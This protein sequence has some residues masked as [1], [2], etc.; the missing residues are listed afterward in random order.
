MMNDSRFLGH[1]KIEFMIGSEVYLIFIISS[2]E[3]FQKFSFCYYFHFT[4]YFDLG[5]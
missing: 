5:F 4:R 1:A 3:I 2:I